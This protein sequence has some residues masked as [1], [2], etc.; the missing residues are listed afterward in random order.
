MRKEF[1]SVGRHICIVIDFFYPP[2][3]KY[4][5]LQFFRYG[6]SGVA[7]MIFDWILYFTIYHFALRQHML[8]F[9]FMTFSSHIAAL[10]LTFPIT[11]FTGFLL[12]K[13]V[14]FTS[15]ELRGKV[16]LFRYSIVVF[17]NLLLNYLGLKLLVD[18]IGLFPTPSKMIVT[19]FTT[20][21]SYFS[22]KKYTFKTHS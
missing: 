22:Q 10:F 14:T 16:Q 11:L 3:R 9:G 19:I 5:T 13:Y 6:I 21:F 15:S 8:S 7:N 20:M 12:Q 4:M 17:T 2:F 18:I 1:I